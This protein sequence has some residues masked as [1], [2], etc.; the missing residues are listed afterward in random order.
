MARLHLVLYLRAHLPADLDPLF[1]VVVALCAEAVY[2]HHGQFDLRLWREEVLVACVE[3]D[4]GWEE[5]D[6]AGGEVE[7]VVGECLWG[8]VWCCCLLLLGRGGSR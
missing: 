5:T 6:G 2:V 7:D 4:E 8:G 1:P 3:A